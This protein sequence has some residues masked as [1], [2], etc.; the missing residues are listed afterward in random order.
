MK[1]LSGGPDSP[2]R[3]RRHHFSVTSA[4][5]SGGR[6]RPSQPYPGPPEERKG[7]RKEDEDA[8]AESQHC[9]LKTPTE[10]FFSVRA[11]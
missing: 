10:V 7:I 6:L 8:G 1:M 2:S 4:Y 3:V 11:K 9:V 5:D